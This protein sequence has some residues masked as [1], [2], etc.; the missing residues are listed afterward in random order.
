MEKKKIIRICTSKCQVPS[1]P[2]AQGAR[3]RG[4]YLGEVDGLVF[5]N[6]VSVFAGKH[7]AVAAV[8]LLRDLL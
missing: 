1:S 3:Q 5:G 8:H 4:V 7:P 6:A 2:R